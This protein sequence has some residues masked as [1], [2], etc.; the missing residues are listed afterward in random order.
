[1]MT[2]QKSAQRLAVLFG[3]SGFVGRNVVRELAK[4]GW[5]VRV[6]V[7][8][9]HLSQFLRPM[10]AVGQVQLAQANVRFPA[11]IAEALGGA[12]AVVN[13]VGVLHQRGPQSFDAV[14]SKGAGAVARAAAAAGAKQFVHVSAIGADGASASLY[15]RTKA[16]GEKAVRDAFPSATIIR[17]SIIF[18]PEDDFFNRFAAMFA[19]APSFLPLPVLFGGGAARMQPVYVDDVADAICAT[20]EDGGGGGET[21][22]LGGPRIYTFRELIEFTL[23]ATGRRRMLASV[24]FPMAKLIGAACEAAGLLPFIT[25]PI[26]RDQVRMLKVDNVVGEG[27]RTFADLGIAPKS[28]EAIAPAYLA[29]FRKYGQFAEVP[30]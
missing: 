3:G 6:A 15:A 28:V 30:A 26:T 19:S 4:R 17:P 22:E 10:G 29:R 14:Q 13:L 9:P 5:R 1:M 24:P 2:T 7:R 27:V 8:R 11:S 12:D 20:L 16:E 25:P 23:T 21:F 18:G